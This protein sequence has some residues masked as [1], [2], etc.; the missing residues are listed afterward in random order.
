MEVLQEASLSGSTTIQR[1]VVSTGLGPCAVRL[2]RGPDEHG[3]IADVFLHGAAGS[4]TTF[5]PL[6]SGAH[7]RDRVLL[8]LPGWGDST[9]GARLGSATVEA[10]AGAV[11]EV[12]NSLGYRSWNLVGHSMGGA[13]A[14]HIA[15]DWPERTL[16]VAAI[17]ATTFGVAGSTRQPSHGL[18]KLPWFVGMLL[19]MRF[20]ALLGNAGRA[21]IR[22]AGNTPFMRLLLAPLFA[23]P[24]AIPAHVIRG[25]ARDGRPASFCAAARAVSQ[26]D[27]ARWHSISCPVIAV[28]GDNDAFTPQSDLDQLASLGPHIRTMTVPRCGHFAIVEQPVLVQE[29]LDELWQR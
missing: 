4:W 22:L 28:R 13:I 10:M 27:F 25:L 12:L 2:Q 8:D 3:H 6:L 23:E 21:L 1:E 16:S 9:E 14:L 15:A 19:L 5:Q 7:E 26:Y 29:L 18:T 24:A 17:S 11:V 20:T